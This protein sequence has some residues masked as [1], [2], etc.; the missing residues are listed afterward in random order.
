MNPTTDRD[1]VKAVTASTLGVEIDGVALIEKF[2][3]YAFESDGG[4]VLLVKCEGNTYK[5][6]MGFDVGSRGKAAI[7][8]LN[9]AFAW[10][11]NNTDA[12]EIIGLVSPD[13]TACIALA[14][15]IYGASFRDSGN[16]KLGSITRKTWQAARPKA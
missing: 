3:G 12:E 16:T 6:T 7:A 9:D 13:N 10:L 1:L 5:L 11:F 2:G 4:V 15:Y 14:P 8:A